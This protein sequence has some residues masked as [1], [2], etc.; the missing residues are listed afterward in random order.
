MVVDRKYRKALAL[1]CL[2]SEPLPNA[3][4]SSDVLRLVSMLTR[5]T[6]VKL[7]VF[8]TINTVVFLGKMCLDR[9]KNH[10]CG[11]KKPED[12]SSAIFEIRTATK[13]CEL[14]LCADP[15]RSTEPT[16]KMKSLKIT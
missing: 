6:Q 7:T 2:M 14:K 5:V 13:Y 3:A 4:N 1:Q 8:I 10:G 15:V 11:Q 16:T 12:T 9:R